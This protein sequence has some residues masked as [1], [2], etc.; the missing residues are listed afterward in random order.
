MKT[1]S[2]EK[3]MKKKRVGRK[4]GKKSSKRR[5]RCK[6]SFISLMLMNPSFVILEL[7]CLLVV[8][9]FRE[10]KVNLG[11][12]GKGKFLI[13]FFFFCIEEGFKWNR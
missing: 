8:G 13:L 6:K 1:P 9:F 5:W 10:V 4:N 2:G 12:I 11:V 3:C 7:F